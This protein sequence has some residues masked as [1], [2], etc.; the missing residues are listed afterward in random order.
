MTL[1]FAPELSMPCAEFCTAVAITRAP[2]HFWI[3]LTALH[4]GRFSLLARRVVLLDG[5]VRLSLC[6]TDDH[7]SLTVAHGESLSLIWH[8]LVMNVAKSWD[9]ECNTQQKT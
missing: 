1:Q 9:G 6:R 2:T 4:Y 3:E 8:L 7:G 5:F